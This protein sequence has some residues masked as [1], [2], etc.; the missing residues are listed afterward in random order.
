MESD[1]RVPKEE[2]GDRSTKKGRAREHRQHCR[3]GK[4]VDG[5]E[6]VVVP[7]EANVTSPIIVGGNQGIV[8]DAN[9]ASDSQGSG[10]FGP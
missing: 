9:Q 5:P 7:N 4:A 1:A 2:L 3:D 10:L 6:M 8:I